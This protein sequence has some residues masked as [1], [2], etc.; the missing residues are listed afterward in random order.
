MRTFNLP[1]Q[2]KRLPARLGVERQAPLLFLVVSYLIWAA[3]TLRWV[4]EYIEQRHPLTPLITA[5]LVL[6]GILLGLEPL[7]TRG[8]LWWAHLYL[9]FQTALVLV[10]SLFYY[11]LDFFAL[12]YLP[13]AG[14]AMFLFSRRTA[15]AWVGALIAV[16]FVGQW[17]QF[18]GWGGL[19]F[20]LLYSAGLVFVATFSVLMLQAEAARQHSQQLLDELQAAHQQLQEYAGQAE[21]LATAK[22]R[23][24][25]ARELHDSVAQTLYGLTLQSE[26]ASRK[27]AAGDTQAVEAYLQTFRANARQT[28]QETRRL[29]FEL[30]PPVLEQ[31]GLV[32]ALLYRLEAVESRSGL[33]VQVDLP[34]SVQL[35]PRQ[36]DALYAIAL[37]ALNNM[38]KHAQAQTVRL[39]L[40]P[41][42][43]SIRLVI[44]DDGLGF[45]PHD[46]QSSSGMGLRSLQERA[47]QV[48]G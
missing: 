27:L 43:G 37:E 14:Q 33:K 3:V 35:S 9:L 25:L 44:T 19:P 21:E 10:A 29:I 32:A 22:E 2:L 15:L 23:N 28:L 20:F 38:L 45:D 17:I 16:T 11:E 30:R 48:G 26:A 13:L 46:P 12:L 8:V 39:A 42:P 47:A 7:I 6:F 4:G 36:E 34:E 24:R 5:M 40:Q 41:A 18:G 1:P 31:E